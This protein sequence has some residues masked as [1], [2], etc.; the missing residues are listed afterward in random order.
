MIYKSLGPLD[1]TI[2]KHFRYICIHNLTLKA[3]LKTR[4]FKWVGVTQIWRDGSLHSMKSN[5]SLCA[6]G[7]ASTMS[8]G[9]QQFNLIANICRSRCLDRHFVPNNSN[10]FKF[11][12]YIYFTNK[13]GWE[14]LV[15]CYVTYLITWPRLFWQHEHFTVN[16]LCIVKL[17]TM[18]NWTCR[19][20]LLFS[21]TL[22]YIVGM[23]G[24]GLVEMGPSR[25]IQS[26]RYIVTCTKENRIRFYFPCLY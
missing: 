3:P 18:N 6:T 2:Y 1:E 20:E 21:Y 16:L 23:V 22:R 11:K 13:M 17:T 7:K 24:F 10:Q 12:L 15:F 26:L 8:K 5:F 19:H 25:P 4:N 9:I 14:K